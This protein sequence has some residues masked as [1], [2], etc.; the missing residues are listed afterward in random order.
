M[1]TPFTVGQTYRNRLGAYEVLSLEPP[2][3]QVRYVEGERAGTLATLD[4]VLQARIAINLGV[5]AQD[6]LDAA[7]QALAPARHPRS[8]A[9]RWGREWA[10]LQPEDF[11]PNVVG[12]T[13]RQ[14]S[15]LAGALA[16]ELMDATGAPF[17]TWPLYR[18]PEVHIYEPAR[19]RNHARRREAKLAFWLNADQACFGLYVEAAPSNM[20]P[21]WDLTRLLALLRD[22]PARCAALTE[23]MRRHTLAWYDM[24]GSN[25]WP[26]SIWTLDQATSLL[27]RQDDAGGE[28]IGLAQLAEHIAALPQERWCDLLLC[29]TLPAA[30]AVAL[31]AGL[32][33]AVVAVYRDLLP[34]YRAI[35][36]TQKSVPEADVAQES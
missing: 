11:K 35:T 36:L 16:Q 18:R 4:M 28:A 31:G 29:A 1:S 13:W 22:D 7:A 3:M 30:E 32:S 19:Y 2:N 9:G 33:H 8:V 10:G 24:E 12:T 23:L 27:A 17:T 25:A 6:V 21:T 26:K 5:E 20:D 15:T 14:R 34:L